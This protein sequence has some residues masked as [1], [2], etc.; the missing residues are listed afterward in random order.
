M[1]VYFVGAGPG[2]PELLTLKADRLLRAC[3]CCI[4]A[5]SLVNPEI[6]KRLPPEAERHDSAGMD[7]PQIIAVME[8]G[9]SQDIDV[10][11][12][13][14]GD[15]SIYGA[16]REQ[17]NE[18]DRLGITYEVVPGVSSFQAAAAA[19]P[20][21][22]TAP[23]ISQTI[24]LTRAAGRTPV[25]PEQELSELGRTRATL[26]LFLSVDQ[27]ERICAVLIPHYG[28]DCPAAVIYRASWPDQ[29]IIRGTLGDLAGQ[30]RAAG[31]K[32]TAQILV[33]R[34][35]SRD[36]PASKLY[37]REFSHGYRQGRSE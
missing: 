14:S 3:R 37:D 22:L 17:M 21:E 25:P 31:I 16:I 12:L 27:L 23:E 18:L 19:L 33:G 20:A 13:H 10:V 2:D 32:K 35:L 24:I 1:K 9:R 5:G 28:A 30:V 34:A 29:Q 8:Q 36:I 26:C 15:P 11:R 7:L 6:L 4:Y